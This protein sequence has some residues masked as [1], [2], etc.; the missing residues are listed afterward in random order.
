MSLF[1]KGQGKTGGR[2]KDVKNRL[3]HAFLKALV[4][5]F[6]QH[7]KEAIRICRVERP[8]EYLR[9][10]ASLML[11]PGS[12]TLLFLT[13]PVLKLSWAPIT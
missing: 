2:A 10:V 5:D 12:F 6:D 9:V 1:E 13:A 7:G 11:P 3:S 8:H 4:D